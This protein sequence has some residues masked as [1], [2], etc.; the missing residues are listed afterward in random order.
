[1]PITTS[2]GRF[3]LVESSTTC[4]P[5]PAA[6]SRS[7]AVARSTACMR[8]FSSPSLS[9][10]QRMYFESIDHSYMRR[11]R[12]GSWVTALAFV[13]SFTGAT[14][15]LSTLFSFARNARLF[16]SGE[17][18]TRVRSG[19]EKKTVRGVSDASSLGG[20]F[21][22]T[23]LAGGFADVTGVTG[24][25]VSS[26]Q[27][28]TARTKSRA[29]AFTRSGLADCPALFAA[30]VA[31][32][33]DFGAPARPDDAHVEDRAEVREG[34]AVVSVLGPR[35]GD[36]RADR[37]RDRERQHAA[38]D[39]HGDETHD[40]EPVRAQRDDHLRPRDV[41]AIAQA[42]QE[43][44]LRAD[45][46][47]ERREELPVDA[48]HHRPAQPT[49]EH[50]QERHDARGNAREAFVLRMRADPIRR[51]ERDDRPEGAE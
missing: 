32:D 24:L 4:T 1:M 42:E 30:P 3:G 11:F 13:G 29:R 20:A 31:L 16:P 40:D 43:R 35:V 18:R 6:S 47:R 15:T 45:A 17:M 25:G 26:P 23:V 8:Q 9:W 39:R 44:R 46:E 12:F 50:D 41:Q 37:V 34:H 14:K 7:C 10:N 48:R 19:F 2:P 27:A 33:G 22:A 21:A 28:T 5:S 38:L 49:D 51:D 36:D